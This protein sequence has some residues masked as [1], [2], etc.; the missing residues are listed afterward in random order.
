TWGTSKTQNM[1]FFTEAQGVFRESGMSGTEALA[2]AKL[3]LPVLSKIYAAMSALDEESAAKMR[4]SSLAMLRFDEMKGGLKS[5]EEFNR[6]ANAGWKAIRSSGGNVDWEQYR[7]FLAK[8]GV[9]AQGLSDSAFYGRFEPLIGELKGGGAGDALMTSFNRLTGGVKIPNQVAHSLVN[10]GLWDKAKVTF[11]NHGGIKRIN[12]NPLKDF[13]LYSS[14]P[15]KW[16]EKYMMPAYDKDH[17]SPAERARQNTLIFGRTGGKLFSLIDRQLPV[18]KMSETAYGQALGISESLDEAKKTGAGAEGEFVA[19]W[20][21]FKKEFGRTVLPQVTSMLVSGASVLR[22][23]NGFMSKNQGA[24]DTIVTFAKWTNPLTAPGEVLDVVK[25]TKK[26][27]KEIHT[28]VQ[29]D[30]RTVATAVT[31]HLEKDAARATRSSGAR[32]DPG[33]SLVP[34]MMHYQP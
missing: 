10:L 17:L 23:L 21:D 26:E 15:T 1:R 4:T 5:P 27:E 6:I 22:E 20:A 2:G 30:G 34:P 18:L 14:D 31:P 13:E 29:I 3:A 33:Q 9:A 8:G 25:P 24:I 19:A 7:Q 16:Y 28:T 32:F 12:G 11:N